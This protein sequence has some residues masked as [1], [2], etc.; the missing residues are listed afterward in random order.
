VGGNLRLGV[1]GPCG[2]TKGGRGDEL[3]DPC[4]PGLTE[5]PE[6]KFDP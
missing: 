3:N 2:V 4:A 1:V 6:F 5:R